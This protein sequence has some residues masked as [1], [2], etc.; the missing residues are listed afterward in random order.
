MEPWLPRNHFPLSCP[1][2]SRKDAVFGRSRATLKDCADSIC[3]CIRSLF[4]SCGRQRWRSSKQL[5]TW[6][7]G[8]N[9]PALT[10]VDPVTGVSVKFPDLSGGGELFHNN[11]IMPGR[12]SFL[13][14]S[15]P[16]VSIIRPSNNERRRDG[17]RSVPDGYGT[18]HRTIAVV[19]PALERACRSSRPRQAHA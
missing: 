18:V 5:Q 16:I 10:A 1:R 14:R 19:L 7:C 12:C 17:C 4:C 2:F 9:A 15:L 3:S 8:R 6:S 13:D 11:F